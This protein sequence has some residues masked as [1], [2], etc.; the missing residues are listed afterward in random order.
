MKEDADAREARIERVS[1]ERCR[2]VIEVVEKAR[3]ERGD[4]YADCV[5]MIYTTMQV[6]KVLIDTGKGEVFTT[7]LRAATLRMLTHLLVLNELQ[8]A[9]DLA[10]TIAAMS[11]FDK[12]D[13][14]DGGG[15]H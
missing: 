10:M 9:V 1:A 7:P 3:R 8:E 13:V 12:K 2:Q 5:M 15:L 14:D 4:K 11:S 6:E